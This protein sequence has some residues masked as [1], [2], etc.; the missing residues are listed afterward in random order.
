MRFVIL[1]DRQESQLIDQL[2]MFAVV[3]LPTLFA[4]C[5]EVIDRRIRERPRWRWGVIAFGVC[6]SALTWLQISR[7]IVARENAIRYTSQQVAAETSKQVTKAVT[8]QY[9][10]MIADQKRQISDLQT[11]LAAQGKDVSAIKSSNIVTGKKPLKVEVINSQPK[12][13]PPLPTPVNVSWTQNASD[14]INGK[15]AL[16]VSL[17]VD[18]FVGIP[19]FLA[20]CDRPCE[21]SN[22]TVPGASMAQFLHVTN[23][24]NAAGFVFTQPRPLAPG[25]DVDWSIVSEDE[26]PIRIMSVRLLPVSDLPESLR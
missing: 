16:K 3:I 4:I 21:T 8:E 23:D 10:Q 18:N 20:T 24:P 26:K 15:A 9:S 6:L 12:N 14:P 11:Q 22:A 13:Q 25:I 7:D 1:L 2:L 5:L 19:A 17:R